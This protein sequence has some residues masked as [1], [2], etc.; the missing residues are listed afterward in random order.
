MRTVH[1]LLAAAFAVLAI[2]L[3]AAA[4]DGVHINDAYARFLP[5]AKSGAAFFEIEN[6]HVEDDR[7]IAAASNVAEKVE[8]HTHIQSAEGMMQMLPVEGG[9]V[10]PAQA[11]AWLQR[12]GDHLMF[13][14]LTEKLKDGDTISVTLT[15]ERAGEVTIDIPVDNAREPGAAMPANVHGG[16]SGMDHGTMQHGHAAP[17]N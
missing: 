4:H 7:L 8:P 9:I 16:M 11:S 17:S 3:A 13:M 15:F 6:H 5:G 2:P 1:T 12:G 14:G 10:I